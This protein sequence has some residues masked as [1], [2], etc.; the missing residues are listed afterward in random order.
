MM[1]M[2][3][4][5]ENITNYFVHRS[6]AQR[7]AAARPYFHPL[8]AAKIMAHTQRPRFAHA[9]DVACGTGHSTRALA[10]IADKVA[11]IDI[12]DEMIAEAVRDERISYQVASAEQIPFPDAHFDLIT[13]GLAFHWLDQPLFLREAARTV[14]PDG[15]LVIYNH[16]F[17]GEMQENKGFS[18]WFE[19][20]YL[21]KFPTPQR[22]ATGIS[23]DIATSHGFTL[24][25]PDD[26]E[27]E[28][29]MTAAQLSAYLLTQTNVISLVENGGMPLAAAAAWIESE[30][31][32]FFSAGAQK[33]KFQG[34]IW[35]LKRL[36]N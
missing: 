29:M 28:E 19:E 10:T 12:S 31:S 6:V 35:Y 16:W 13:V 30:V 17:T 36:A 21:R 20:V 15:W 14:R 9:L 1:V 8:V 23:L 27:N 24:V 5:A 4:P 32:P 3:Q 34:S 2:Q 33:M 18:P 22:R 26:F 7:Y 11:A 25:G